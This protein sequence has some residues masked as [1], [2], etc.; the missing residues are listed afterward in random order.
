MALSPFALD[1]AI[2]PRAR[3]VSDTRCP[4][5]IAHYQILLPERFRMVDR[6][7]RAP[8]NEHSPVSVSFIRTVDEPRTELEVVGFFLRREI[9]PADALLA[10]L[11]EHTILEER[12]VPSPG[13]DLLDVLTRKG[14][15][16]PYLS[17]WWTVKDGGAQGGRLYLLE[18]RV[19]E[20][21]YPAVA[22][23]LSA[24]LGSFRLLNPTPWDYFEQLT[25]L[26]QTTPN[27]LLCFYPESWQLTVA[28]DGS[29]GPYVAHLWQV[30]A[31]QLLGRITIMS[32]PEAAAPEEVLERYASLGAPVAWEPVQ[33]SEP[34][35]GLET[36]WT[37]RGT[38]SLN[39]ASVE[40]SVHIGQRSGG[41]ILLGLAGIPTH[42]DAMA[43]G[44]VRRA[45]EVVH[46]TLRVAPA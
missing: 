24:M 20:S 29:E 18:G 46:D 28:S 32:M 35:G 39:E 44:A 25:S 1:P 30:L 45:L 17:R 27:D 7:C 43:A 3:L 40:L 38:S 12:R 10:M 13:G 22:D 19:A 6:D 14:G 8:S 41:T 11:Q 34:F 21:A 9:A 4:D 15:A 37:A 26:A 23:E 33:P 5:E 36:A 42:V 16:E 31:K 2:A